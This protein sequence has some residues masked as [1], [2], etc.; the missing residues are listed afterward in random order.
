MAIINNVT[1]VL[2]RIRVKLYPNYL[3]NVEGA[4]IARTDSEA[5]LNIEQ[6][7]AALKNRGG[8]GGDYE[9]LVE[10]VKQFFDEAAY[11]L[12]DGFA[13]NV[14]YYSVHPNVG[15]TFNTVTEAHDHKKHPITFRFRANNKLRKLVEHIGVDI[16]GI[17]DSSGWIDEFIDA[18]E[19]SI[20]TLYVPGNQFILH[21]HK[22]KVAGD[23]PGVGVFF[24]P[25]SDPSKAVK[26]KRI[27]ENTSTK[28]IGITPK[29]EELHN[30]IE[31][32]T[33][34]S[35]SGSA[36]LKTVRTIASGFTVEEA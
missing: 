22:I 13:V 7:C 24:V 5:S 6:V 21:G 34:F 33:Q 31:V 2:H 26:V 32:R 17:A 11:Q 30:R 4:Y 20:N 1:E 28:I 25:V 16:E 27:A 3:P 18:D 23:A 9:D 15:G 35:G 29:T 12:C 36:F 14:G 8:F 19:N 10:A